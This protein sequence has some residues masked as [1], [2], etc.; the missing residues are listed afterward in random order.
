MSDKIKYTGIKIKDGI[1]VCNKCE[2]REVECVMHMDCKDY[3][4]N[5]YVC[6]KCKNPIT[7]TE[8]RS[9]ES[10]MYWEDDE[11]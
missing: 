6:T 8:K 10:M 9:K 7:V 2:N 11:K 5:S 4:I 1:L 3:F